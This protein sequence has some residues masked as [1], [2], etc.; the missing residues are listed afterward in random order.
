M[1]ALPDISVLVPTYCRTRLLQDALACFLQQSYPGDSELVILND[2]DNQTLRFD[3]PRVRI[4][5]E[6]VR[7]PLGTKRNRLI[8]LAR[9]DVVTLWDDDDIYLSHRLLA[10]A[11]L[12]GDRLAV[13]ER[14][15]WEEQADGTLAIRP[16]SEHCAH[17]QR[18]PPRCRPLRP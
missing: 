7:S 16:A 9:Y 1:S 2:F 3:N 11:P 8:N 17:A 10:T 6:T 15:E 18:R 5:N 13:H 14:M 12:L 4:V